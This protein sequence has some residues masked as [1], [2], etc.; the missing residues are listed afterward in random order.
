MERITLQVFRRQRQSKI[1]QESNRLRSSRWF[2]KERQG[3]M[4]VE[5][6]RPRR[7]VGDLE[8]RK[9][10]EAIAKPQ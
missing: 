7:K 1:M 9:G 8:T 3:V 4:R 5:P 10:S 6:T 2:R